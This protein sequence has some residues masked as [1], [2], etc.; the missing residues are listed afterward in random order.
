[1]A[2]IK[3]LLHLYSEAIEGYQGILN[4][5][6]DYIPALKGNHLISGD[7]FCLS[8]GLPASYRFVKVECSF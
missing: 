1:M 4:D 5:K 7:K 8:V 3:H 6:S 2:S